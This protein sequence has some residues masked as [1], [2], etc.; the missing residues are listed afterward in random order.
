LAAGWLAVSTTGAIAANRIVAFESSEA[1]GSSIHV[2]AQMPVTLHVKSEISSSRAQVGDTVALQ[3][4]EDVVVSGYVV[5][6]HGADGLAEITTASPAGA[7][8]S[9]QL[10][11]QFKWVRAVDG[12][13]IGVTGTASLTGRTN[14][15]DSDPSSTLSDSSNA[16]QSAGATQVANVLQRASGFFRNITAH[17][18]GNEAAIEPDRTFSVEVRNPNGVNIISSLRSSQPAT[19]A[20]DDSDVK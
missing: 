3:V 8:S 15:N 13:K 17:A 12:S 16:A 20:K 7:N 4:A 5:I 1:F 11:V 9:G 2:P 6:A 18:K 10:L 14:S 19:T